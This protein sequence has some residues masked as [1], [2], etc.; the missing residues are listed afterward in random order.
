[1]NSKQHSIE[2]LNR[3]WAEFSN[4]PVTNGDSIESAFYE[5][6]AGTDRLDIWS[7]F[8]EQYPTG[9]AVHLGNPIANPWANEH[10]TPQLFESGAKFGLRKSLVTTVPI[11][12][13][14]PV[15]PDGKVGYLEEYV[16]VP[17]RLFLFPV[18]GKW[19][20]FTPSGQEVAKD[21]PIEAVIE[22]QNLCED[23][24]FPWDGLFA[25][26][27]YE[28][29]GCQTFAETANKLLDGTT[30][31]YAKIPWDLNPKEHI[32]YWLPNEVYNGLSVARD[33]PHCIY[34]GDDMNRYSEE[35]DAFIAL[36]EDTSLPAEEGPELCDKCSKG[37][38]MDVIT[39]FLNVPDVHQKVC[40]N[41]R[42][43]KLPS[44]SISY[45][46]NWLVDRRE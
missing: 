15:V 38:R 10:G 6:P 29:E 16:S 4:M 39:D 28:C 35:G 1:M 36:K 5:W 43:V 30:A 20:C 9:L 12:V 13:R 11:F 37:Y 23:K 27:F 44:E 45:F 40:L 19:K 22:L 46:R 17:Y 42:H 31:V 7:W 2:E 3:M 41:C 32:T 33:T 21:T 14:R 8:D 24:V 34:C 25:G 26:L 18:G